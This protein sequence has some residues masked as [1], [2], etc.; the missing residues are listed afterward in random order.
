MVAVETVAA[1]TAKAQLKRLAKATAPLLTPTFR[2]DFFL[3]A[4]C[5]WQ[6]SLDAWSCFTPG[7]KALTPLKTLA[8]IAWRKSLA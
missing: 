8:S 2:S 1:A 6:I 4:H 3:D 7:L 5:L